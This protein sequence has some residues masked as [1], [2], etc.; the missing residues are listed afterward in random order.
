MKP[1]FSY[2]EVLLL[3]DLIETEKEVKMLNDILWS[4]I[5]RYKSC[6][7]FQIRER[8]KTRINHLLR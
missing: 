5:T 6:D 8:L 2:Y 4:E 7:W 1:S 3:I